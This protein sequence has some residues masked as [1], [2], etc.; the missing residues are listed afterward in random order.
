MKTRGLA[1]YILCF[2]FVFGTSFAYGG[3]TLVAP[4]HDP[5]VNSKGDMI[6]FNGNQLYLRKGGV[7]VNGKGVTGFLNDAG[8]VA[9]TTEYPAKNILVFTGAGEPTQ[10]A[11]G[12]DLRLFGLNNQGQVLYLNVNLYLWDPVTGSKQVAAV[13][14]GGIQSASLGEDRL[15]YSKVID[16]NTYTVFTYVIASSTTIQVSTLAGKNYDVAVRGQ[17]IYWLNEPPGG[18]SPLLCWPGGS[19]RPSD[20]FIN[21]GLSRQN[22]SPSSG[23]VAFIMPAFDG[24]DAIEVY[25]PGV[26]WK[27]N[28]KIANNAYTYEIGAVWVDDTRL[29][30]GGSSGV[31]LNQGNTIRQ[32]FQGPITYGGQLAANNRHLVWSSSEN[33]SGNVYYDYCRPSV[34]MGV[35]SLLLN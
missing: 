19:T 23:K 15:A 22:I 7:T 4:G 32:I 29:A 5:Q 35:I 27:I 2:L 21:S 24:T 17:Y 6:W 12:T 31:F 16:A 20:T 1:L 18:A 30:Y 3:A 34:N 9:F 11:S 10:V 13:G 25:T 28:V 8:T 26:G 14:A 33:V